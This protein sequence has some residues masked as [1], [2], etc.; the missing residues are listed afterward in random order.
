[1]TIDGGHAVPADGAPALAVG[2]ESASSSA[3]LLRILTAAL[4]ATQSARRPDALDLARVEV[5]GEGGGVDSRE[6]FRVASL[7]RCS[8]DLYREGEQEGCE[9]VG[10]EHYRSS[11]EET[12]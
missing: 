12:T 5:P 6:A 10:D 8:G 7:N 9:N 1:L 2:C 11:G 4:A 3:K